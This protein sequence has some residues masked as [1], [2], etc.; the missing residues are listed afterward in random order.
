[1]KKL[2]IGLLALGSLTAFSQEV[3]LSRYDFE[4][5]AHHAEWSYEEKYSKTLDY[6]A[7]RR[8][9]ILCKKDFG[10]FAYQVS[11]SLKSAPFIEGNGRHQSISVYNA[12]SGQVISTPV[13]YYPTGNTDAWSQP[14]YRAQLFDSIKCGVNEKEETPIHELKME[15]SVARVKLITSIAEM[16]SGIEKLINSCRETEFSTNCAEVKCKALN[17]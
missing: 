8:A 3:D 16:S 14:I 10:K 9:N 17:P 6:L 7:R 11:F 15:C 1:M 2:L 5:L 4:I 13:A 12:D